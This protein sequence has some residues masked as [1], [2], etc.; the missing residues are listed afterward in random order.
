[1]VDA[2]DFR[3]DLYYRISAFPL[4][5]PSLRERA[6]DIPLLVESMLKRFYPDYE[7]T[8]SDA[9][10]KQLQH[11]PFPG[12]IRELSNIVQRATLMTNSDVIET[13]HLPEE[14]LADTGNNNKTCFSDIVSLKELEK[15]YL[16]WALNQVENK[17]ELAKKLGISERTLYRKL[18]QL[19]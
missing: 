4:H 17:D 10:S 11:Y 7:I 1:M 16:I 12:N 14:C 13:H 9:A 6:E 19:D 2:G 3:Q 8:M 5:L 15:R 18:E